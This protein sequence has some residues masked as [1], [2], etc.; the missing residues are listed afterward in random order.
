MRHGHSA[1]SGLIAA[2]AALHLTSGA[3]AADCRSLAGNTF[4]NAQMVETN[5][6]TAP[7]TI[8]SLE[9]RGVTVRASFCRARG[10][11]KPSTDSHINIEVWLPPARTWN[12][13]YQGMGNGG[14]AGTLSY[15]AMSRALESGY[16]VSS[17]DT[18]HTGRGNQSDWAVG[19]PEKVVDLG[20]RAIHETAVASTAVIEAYYGKAPA[21]S[22]FAGCSTGGRQGLIEAQR[23]PTDYN[24][25]VVGAPANY[26]PQMLAWTVWGLQY[27]TAQPGNWLSPEKLALINKASLAACHGVNGVLDDPGQCRFDPASLL[28]EAGQTD[29]CL[30]QSEVTAMRNLY[31]DLKD[32]SGKLIYPGLSPGDEASWGWTFGPSEN[33]GVGSVSGPY[34]IGF[35][36]DL[37]FGNPDWDF[38]S[39]QL[40]RDLALAVESNAGKSVYAE[41]PD[42]SAF[43]AAGGKILYYHGWNDPGIPARASINYY[44]SVAAK[45]GGVPQIDSFYRLFLGPGMR[46]CGPGPG[47]MTAEQDLVSALARWVENGVAPSEVTA[48]LYKDNDPSKGVAAQR[49]W[50]AYPSVARYDGKGDP[51][52][53]A[54]Y[55]C[56]APKP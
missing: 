53:A 13:K 41:N 19:H 47:P 45:M 35:Y 22:Y 9:G 6:V 55:V 23:F 15:A 32:S 26:W 3:H 56:T 54:S 27:I 28:C 1:A 18:G 5:E 10:V 33:R 30:T 16:A 39:F 11:I 34:G 14:F 49:P 21:Y 51:S 8:T 12:G 29:G 40:E 36:R 46:H 4:G 20:W 2:I 25:I 48:T 37:V 52:K 38:R 43:K 50:C 44:D 42:L 31:D 7:I 24:G 17:T